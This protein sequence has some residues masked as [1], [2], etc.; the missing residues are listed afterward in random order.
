MQDGDEPGS[1]EVGG[2]LPA[3]PHD[4]VMSCVLGIGVSLAVLWIVAWVRAW[5]ETEREL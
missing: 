4:S 5:V 3:A 2:V 1:F